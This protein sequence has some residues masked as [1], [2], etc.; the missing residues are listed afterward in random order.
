VDS[1]IL[2]RPEMSSIDPSEPS[3]QP[4]QV[5]DQS[6]TFEKLAQNLGANLVQLKYYN[7]CPDRCIVT[8]G[9]WILIAR[10]K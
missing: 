8:K 3:F 9:D 5:T 10:Q 2:I 1:I 6:I 7:A 4:Y